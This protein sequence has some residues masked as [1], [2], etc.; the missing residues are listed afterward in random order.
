MRKRVAA[1]ANLPVV[2][3][4]LV[5]RRTAL[6]NVTLIAI[7]GSVGKTTAKECLAAILRR[8][9]PTWASASAGNGRF[10]L[11]LVLLRA[12][13]SHRFI[14]AE[15][16]ILKRGRMW[17]S[18]L[19]LNPNLTVITQVNWQHAMNFCSLEE[20][21]TEKAKLL[22]PLGRD[23]LAILNADN[24]FV[25][26]MAKTRPCRVRTFGVEQS[27]DVN[28][29]NVQAQWPE[30]LSLTVREGNDERRIET[31]FVGAHWAP[32]VLAAI[33]AARAVGASWQSCT[34]AL[35]E[36]EPFPARLTS[37]RLPNGADLLRDEYN[38]SF[39]TL[40]KALEILQQAN[41]TRR[42]L[43][44]GHIKDTPQFGDQGPEEVGRAAANVADVL[45]LWGGFKERYRDAALAEGMSSGNIHTFSTQRDLGD[46]IRQE[47][48]GGD[49][50][51]L[52]GYWNDHMTR[53]AFAQF[54]TVGCDL[55][56]CLVHSS[57]DACDQMRFQPDAAVD[58]ELLRLLLSGQAR[59]SRK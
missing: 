54:G 50:I 48:G 10:D 53:I 11:P 43:A 51:L 7:S 46:H 29:E 58:V 24:S 38:G 19:L 12:R 5:W 8:E 33:A 56:F 37:L 40:Q 55:E 41:C 18:A 47:T 21:A 26:D 42:I 4:A 22:D 17:R 35:A 9:A 6:R 44:I 59:I 49:L 15:V 23:G 1:V 36:L 14:V 2:A 52:K 45:L 20:I 31:R 57:C 30:R 34:E 28:G 16:G 27:A 13:P 39:A 25:A 32:S 3:A